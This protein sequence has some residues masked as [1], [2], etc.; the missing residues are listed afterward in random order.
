MY[1]GGLLFVMTWSKMCFILM[2]MGYES[3]GNGY[4]LFENMLSQLNMCFIF[5]D[6]EVRIR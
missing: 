1:L 5:Y 2:S 4:I 6:Y 3:D